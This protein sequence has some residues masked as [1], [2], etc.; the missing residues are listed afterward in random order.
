ML[1]I[2][3]LVR[4]LIYGM[5]YELKIIWGLFS[6]YVLAAQ[7]FNFLVMR[8][9]HQYW[10]RITFTTKGYSI[11]LIIRHYLEQICASVKCSPILP[12]TVK[13]DAIFIFTLT[14]HY[15]FGPLLKQSRHIIQCIQRFARLWHNLKIDIIGSWCLKENLLQHLYKLIVNSNTHRHQRG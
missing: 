9:I 2:P 10:E 6:H 8:T 3:S 15:S 14:L 12:Y 13:V 7:I 11:V 4:V 1:T 5:S